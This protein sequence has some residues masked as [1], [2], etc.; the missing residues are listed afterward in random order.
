MKSYDQPKQH[1]KKQRHYFANK[2]L[3]SQSYGFCSSHVCI[4][5]L[6]YK[7]SWMPKN[8]CFWTVVLKKTLVSPR[9][10]KE[11]QPVNPKGNQSCIFIGRTNAEAETPIL[12]PLDARN[13]LIGKNPGAG[14][15]WRQEERRTTEDEMDGWHRQLNGHEFEQAL[16][17]GDGQGSG[18]AAVHGVSKS[19]TRLSDWT[20]VNQ[21]GSPRFQYWDTWSPV[22][23]SCCQA[24][25]ASLVYWLL[26]LDAEKIKISR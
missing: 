5:E 13:W 8:W 25:P 18:H 2:G 16:G 21:G 23:M 14:K 7:E 19:Q 22:I 17:V 3:Y 1:I 10:C 24:M 9:D 20:E 15:D 26:K 4:Q 12:R 6:D 11:I